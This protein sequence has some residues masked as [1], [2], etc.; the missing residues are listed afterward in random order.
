MYPYNKRR[1]SDVAPRRLGSADFLVVCEFFEA[2]AIFAREEG[3]LSLK[4]IDSF[5]SVK[6]F[7]KN[8]PR[9]SRRKIN[10]NE[11]LKFTIEIKN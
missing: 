7:R 5:D 4:T 10:T 9:G 3:K 6:L 1:I 11:I 2:T 8:A